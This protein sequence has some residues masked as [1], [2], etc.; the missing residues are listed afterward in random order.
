MSKN[1]IY[2]RANSLIDLCEEFDAGL[3]EEMRGVSDS[4]DADLEEIVSINGRY[5][6]AWANSAQL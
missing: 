6:L 1:D 5:E 3:V 2:S 4:V